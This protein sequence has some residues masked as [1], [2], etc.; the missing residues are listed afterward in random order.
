M[1]NSA[2]ELV[3]KQA[4]SPNPEAIKRLRALEMLLTSTAKLE[5]VARLCKL[6]VST[7][8]RLR[9]EYKADPEKLAL[10]I[11]SKLQVHSFFTEAE[12]HA[13]IKQLTCMNPAPTNKA[14]LMTTLREALPMKDNIK[15]YRLMMKAKEEM[16]LCKRMPK[17][18]KGSNKITYDHHG[19]VLAA[20]TLLKLF[21]EEGNM[22]IFDTCSFQND[23]IGVTCWT[24]RG[25]RP[26]LPN[27]NNSRPMHL[28]CLISSTDVETCSISKES[29]TKHTTRNFILI[30]EQ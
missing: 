27:G 10:K 3:K 6:S 17:I 5:E 8:C 11:E 22:M 9:K 29:V 18:T 13:V 15:D 16:N 26:M 25:H 21:Y 4:T 30:S 1:Q 23:K 19:Y 20:T 14:T 24:T 7:V 28:Y 2:I 12:K